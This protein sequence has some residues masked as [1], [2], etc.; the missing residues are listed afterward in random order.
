MYLK[1]SLPLGFLRKVVELDL[2]PTQSTPITF[3]RYNRPESGFL[4]EKR[5]G[6]SS[7][8]VATK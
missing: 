2:D 1:I 6:L 5:L 3:V 7:D 8:A 4:H